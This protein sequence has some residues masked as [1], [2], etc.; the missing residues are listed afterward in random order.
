[1]AYDCTVIPP[2]GEITTVLGAK[3]YHDVAFD[4]SGYIYG[5]D[6]SSLIKTDEAGAW[7]IFVPA[8][9][10]IEQMDWLLDG[11]L[12][13]SKQ[14]G[15]LVRISPEGGTTT[16]V[17]D[18]YAYEVMVGPDDLV[19]A[20]NNGQVWRIY[21]E[22]G[23]QEMLIPSVPG[24]ARVLAFNV[25]YSKMYIG[26]LTGGDLFVVDL[27]AGLNP[28]GDPVLFAMVLRG[29]GGEAG[30]LLCELRRKGSA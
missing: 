1:V 24:S 10:G 6:N 25:A 19:Y 13:V 8:L 9:G 23:L 4:Q 21:P 16:I 5:S 17:G 26:T 20:A 28:I 11:D 3:G 27:D 15:S 12:V 2:L 22:T 7:E 18:L 14:Q 30:W 29:I